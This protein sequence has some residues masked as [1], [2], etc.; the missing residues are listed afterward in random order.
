M[1]IKTMYIVNRRWLYITQWKVQNFH[2]KPAHLPPNMTEIII[3]F[4]CVYNTHLL[5]AGHAPPS[6]GCLDL[7]YTQYILLYA[8]VKVEVRFLVVK[9]PH[10]GSPTSIILVTLIPTTQ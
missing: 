6:L 3:M 7:Q 9:F 4:H 10:T 2:S 8:P 1:K 5:V